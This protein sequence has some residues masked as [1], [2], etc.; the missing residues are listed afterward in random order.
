MCVDNIKLVHEELKD[1]RDKDFDEAKRLLHLSDRIYFL[2]FGFGAV[3]TSRL[4][5]AKIPANRAIATATGF[6]QNEVATISQKCGGTISIYPN[7]NI[8]SLFR[9]V[10]AWE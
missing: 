4:Q 2:G 5:L 7:H 10:V 1:G 3:N 9:D 6:T 8:E